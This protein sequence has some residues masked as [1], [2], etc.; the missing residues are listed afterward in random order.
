MPGEERDHVIEQADLRLVQEG[1]EIA[2]HGR[3]QH[4][5]DQDQR[6]PE[7]MAAELAIDQI[8]QREADDGLQQD[9]PEHEMRR[10]LHALPDF[11]VRQDRLVVIEPDIA[12]RRVGAVGAVVREGE[13]DRPDQREEVDR[14][15]QDHRRRDEEPGDGP[16]GEAPDPAGDR[17]RGRRASPWRS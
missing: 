17:G 16:V 4:H 7:A 3:R 12:Q 10:R 11:R 2:D 1:P 5:R 9:R 6:G 13:L 8:G 14:E 15:Q